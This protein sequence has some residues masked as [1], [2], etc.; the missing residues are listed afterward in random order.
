MWCPKCKA[1][2]REG[3]TV[4]ADCHIPLVEELVEEE[5]G[6]EDGQGDDFAD[7]SEEGGGLDISDLSAGEIEELKAAIEEQ[8]SAMERP[9]Y[10]RVADQIEDVKSSGYILTAAGIAGLI[11]VVLT[12]MGLL[13][14]RLGGPGKYITFF[15]MG[16]LFMVFLVNGVRSILKVPSLEEEA[17]REREK[18][19][20]V[21]NWFLSEYDAAK[22]DSRTEGLR[23]GT[24]DMYFPRTA[25][26]REKINEHFMELDPSFTDY[27]IEELYVRIFEGETASEDGEEQSA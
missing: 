7:G 11:L 24:A 6:Q 16:L 20:G 18:E 2:Y 23:D 10:R 26:M 15:V 25:F 9:A 4:C 5:N 17:V 19:E 3:F 1:E 22:I 14:I 21:K 8:R 13:P 27:I 12:W